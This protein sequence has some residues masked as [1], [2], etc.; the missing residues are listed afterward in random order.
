MEEN[1]RGFSTAKGESLGTVGCVHLGHLAIGT[2][3]DELVE[4][5]GHP[6]PPIV[7]LHS[8]KSL[9][10]SFMSPGRRLMERSHQVIAS[11][12]RDVEAMFEV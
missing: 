5:G 8:V 12:F 7:L 4:E 2:S 3:C 9:E 6:R 10:E 1:G 11:G